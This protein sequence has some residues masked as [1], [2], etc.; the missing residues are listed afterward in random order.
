MILKDAP[1]HMMF[2]ASMLARFESNR[3]PVWKR[4]ISELHCLFLFGTI[5]V[6]WAGH[7]SV[8]ERARVGFRQ[9]MEDTLREFREW[10]ILRVAS[11]A[12][13]SAHGQPSLNRFERVKS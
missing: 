5:L 9:F 7:R 1:G 8:F 12:R 2:Q 6:V 10:E 13:V 3:Q 4:A 11:V